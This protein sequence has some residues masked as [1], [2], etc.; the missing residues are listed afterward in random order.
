MVAGTNTDLSRALAGRVADLVRERSLSLRG[1]VRVSIEIAMRE[2]PFQG[3]KAMTTDYVATVRTGDLEHTFEGH[4][5]GF[6]EL[7]LRNGV[8]EQAAAE[9]VSYLANAPNAR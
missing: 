6:A 5:L 8:I 7:T 1:T 9:I 3:S 2:A 4:L